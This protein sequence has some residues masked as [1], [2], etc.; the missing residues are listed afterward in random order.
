L[1]VLKEKKIKSTIRQCDGLKCARFTEFNTPS[2]LDPMLFNVCKKKPETLSLTGP[3]LRN[4]REEACSGHQKEKVGPSAFFPLLAPSCTPIQHLF[5]T[6]LSH[7][8]ACLS[9]ALPSPGAAAEW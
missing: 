5:L 3:G 9:L 1:R 8:L 4:Q 7:P 2:F 6:L